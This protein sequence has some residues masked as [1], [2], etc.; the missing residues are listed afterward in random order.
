M[1]LESG[2]SK[3]NKDWSYRVG[4]EP[5]SEMNKRSCPLPDSRCLAGELCISHF[6]FVKLG[7]L[8]QNGGVR[9]YK[10]ILQVTSQ[11]WHSLPT[12]LEVLK[13]QEMV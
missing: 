13:T 6:F 4:T 12:A 7:V 9:G 11:L 3:G 10:I 5:Y 1:R 8:L 2:I